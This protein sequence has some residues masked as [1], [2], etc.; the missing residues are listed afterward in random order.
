[1]ARDRYQVISWNIHMSDSDED[2]Q[3]D[4]KKGTP[5]YDRLFQLK[6]LLDDIG[7]ACR[8][9]YQPRQN[10]SVDERMVATKA[11]T[12]MTQYMKA[13]PTKWGFKLFV[14]ADSSNG[15]TL[16][17]AVYTGKSVFASG[18]G[19]AYDSVMS[20]MNKTNL[21]SGYNVYVD[22]F[23]TSPKLFKDL[24]NMNFGACGTYR[25]NRRGCP[26]TTTNAIK[27]RI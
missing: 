25:D 26:R 15:Y 8:A 16:D 21:G 10:L 20:L 14:L 9:F 27:K 24:Y 4:R 5:A 12:G 6:P 22:N 7:H 2:V 1:M 3:N 18:V 13:K 19:L 23:Y 17:F 11:H